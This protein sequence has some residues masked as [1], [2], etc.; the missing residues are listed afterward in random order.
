MYCSPLVSLVFVSYRLCYPNVVLIYISIS[1]MLLSILHL[2]GYTDEKALYCPHRDRVT[3][4]EEGSAYC[5]IIG[6]MKYHRAFSGMK[7]NEILCLSP[8]V[9]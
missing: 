2:V 8:L 5:N 6:I 3:S 9:V 1:H 4:F 7:C